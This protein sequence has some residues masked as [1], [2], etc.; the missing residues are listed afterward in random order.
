[1]N[2][3]KHRR[4]ICEIRILYRIFAYLSKQ[5]VRPLSLAL[6]LSLSLFV[7]LLLLLF[8]L[9]K[10]CL[11]MPLRGSLVMFIY[12]F[13]SDVGRYMGVYAIILRPYWISLTIYAHL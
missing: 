9:L 5:V 6:P 3:I 10:S 7:K 8:E 13:A 1:M 11:I 4:C 12:L 2:F